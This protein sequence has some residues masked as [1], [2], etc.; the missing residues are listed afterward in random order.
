[1]P[2]LSHMYAALLIAVFLCGCGQISDLTYEKAAEFEGIEFPPVSVPT[3]S[4]QVSS[5]TSVSAP[6]PSSQTSDP[7]SG[8]ADTNFEKGYYYDNLSSE[9]QKSYEIL[10]EGFLDGRSVIGGLSED[11][12]EVFPAVRAIYL[13]RPD[14]PWLTN[15]G[16]Q[17]TYGTGS[18]VYTPE[19]QVPYTLGESLAEKADEAADEILSG[20]DMTA[21]DYEKALA[22]FNYLVDTIDY[23]DADVNCRDIY[24]ALVEKK[25]VCAGYSAAAKYLL[26]R[27]EI[28]CITVTGDV[29]PGNRPH[30]WNIIWLDGEPYHMDATWGDPSFGE[31]TSAPDG[32]RNYAYFLMTT[33]DI[34]SERIIDEDLGTLPVCTSQNDYYQR[35]GLH[36]ASYS[37]SLGA[38]LVNGYKEGESWVTVSFADD[39]SM[40]DVLY[41]LF[42]CGDYY[43]WFNNAGISPGASSYT[44]E[45]SANTLTVFFR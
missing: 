44:V 37:D 32:Y 36:L 26:D 7:I 5:G 16:G 22:V 42:D 25:A 30:A 6:D 14:L 31:D 21:S 38:L 11:S 45:E 23:S 3:G 19:Y 40:D 34:L 20:I 28:P 8:A 33:D 15:G 9:Q 17:L 24:G 29:L 1:M 27:L 2:K 4:S 43:A 18:G 41:Q 39:I 10:L 35:E 12:A 13:D